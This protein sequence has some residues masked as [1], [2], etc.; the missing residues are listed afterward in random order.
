MAEEIRLDVVAVGHN[1]GLDDTSR[2]LRGARGESDKMGDSFRETTDATFDLDRAVGEARVEVQRLREEFRKTGDRSLLKEIRAQERDL[3]AAMKIAGDG[4]ESAVS[5]GMDF[6]GAGIRPRNALIGIVAGSL[7]ILSPMIGAAIAGAV[8]GTVGTGGLIG[9]VVS[10][11]KD[12]RVKVAAKQF[13][14]TVSTSFFGGG[15]P[16][17]EPV[18]NSLDLLGDRFVNLNLG[19]TFAKAA[20][21]VDDLAEGV[22]DFADGLNRGL[23]RT[24]DRSGEIIPAVAFGLG[25]L[26]DGLGDMIGQMAESEGTIEGIKFLFEVIAETAHATGTTVKFLGDRFDELGRFSGRLSG[27]LEDVAE[28]LGFGDDNIFARINDHIEAV[29][30]PTQ[31]LETSL[32][33]LEP[34]GKKAASGLTPVATASDEVTDAVVKMREELT[35]ATDAALGADNAHLRFKEGILELKESVK[36][37]G[38]SLSENTQKGIDNRQMI[39]GLISD[40]RA[41][42]DAAIDAA[43]GNEEAADRAKAAYG[44]QLDALGD[45][46]VKL[47]FNKRLIEQIIGRYDELASRPNIV[48][49][50]TI[51]EV[52]DGEL[53]AKANPGN[54]PGRASGGPIWPGDWTVGEEGPERL[55]VNADGT[56][57]V[58]PNVGG[59]RSSSGGRG[60][61]GGS[62][63]PVS[64]NGAAAG[65]ALFGWLV[66][67]IARRGGT[68]A[69]LGIKS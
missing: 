62:A 63:R 50:I 59:S 42:R 66:R 55:R 67:E 18:I 24:L 43:G 68:L 22:A 33:K 54:A 14:D 11:A 5:R 47:G 16:F 39:N 7:A 25:R 48:K 45:L 38:T 61:S 46:L 28:A 69:V 26:G 64:L 21:Y 37:H 1:K 4:F 20:P 9:G 15:G 34:A 10:A 58:Y 6:G 23:N 40:L 41:E 60:S 3:Q 51:R 32:V 17:V 13:G 31:N 35:R 36:E 49:S 29:T 2:A 52:R 53:F 12:P 8:A 19:A 57:Y 30:G 56:G 27:D 65:E 44:K